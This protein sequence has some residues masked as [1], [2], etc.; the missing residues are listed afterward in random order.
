MIERAMILEKKEKIEPTSLVLSP[1]GEAP[2]QPETE[3]ESSGPSEVS[4][5]I[6][7]LEEMEKELVT[8]AMRA[9]GNNQTRAAE[10]LGITR[11]QLRYRLK[12][13]DLIA[14]TTI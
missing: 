3:V 13:F 2:T 14:P 9:S 5:G 4:Q 11:D 12:K 10:L 6:P 8:R 7:S 1:V